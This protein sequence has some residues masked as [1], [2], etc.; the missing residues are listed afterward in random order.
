MSVLLL[1][2]VLGRMLNLVVDVHEAAVD[3]RQS[4]DLVLQI[5]RE[6]VR[7]PERHLGVAEC[8]REQ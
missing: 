8:Q 3:V 7:L 5:L 1:L 2:A 4:L 6:V